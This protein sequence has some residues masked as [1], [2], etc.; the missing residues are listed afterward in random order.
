MI[1]KYPDIN[2]TGCA[3]LYVAQNSLGDERIKYLED[4]IQKYNDSMYGDGV[5]VGAYARFMMAEEYKA[6]G[7]DKK[8]SALYGELRVKY[9]DAV[10]HRGALLID[11]I[12]A[13]TK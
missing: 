5:Q 3:V 6:K 12:G 10:D 2:R 1:Q 9:A 13:E 8:A 11:L 7:E 4:C